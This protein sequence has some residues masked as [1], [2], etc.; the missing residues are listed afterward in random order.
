M[1]K[2][3]YVNTVDGFMTASNLF[4][5]DDKAKNR[6][7]LITLATAKENTSD[8]SLDILLERYLNTLLDE[9]HTTLDRTDALVH[10][11]KDLTSDY[12]TVRDKDDITIEDLDRRQAIINIG[13]RICKRESIP[14]GIASILNRAQ[15]GLN[16]DRAA[17]N[18]QSK[19]EKRT[20]SFTPGI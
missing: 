7:N 11:F 1:E 3:K 16:K 13:A 9:N 10:L 17:Y 6:A 14:E 2:S 4:E 8:E 12:S 19:A 5:T 18:R 15:S 20:K